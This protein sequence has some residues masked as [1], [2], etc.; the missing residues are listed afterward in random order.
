MINRVTSDPHFWHRRI[1]TFQNMNKYRH[2]LYETVEEMN[3]GIIDKF[4]EGVESETTTYVLG[5]V[6]LANGKAYADKLEGIL[7]A[8]LGDFVLVKGNHDNDTTAAV[9]KNF[10]FDTYD[11][12]EFDDYETKIC[13]SHFP[14]A[15]W[16]KS[17]YGSVM[18]HGHSHGTYRA[19]GGRILDVGWDVHG[20]VLG[21]HEAYKM[22]MKNEI[23]RANDHH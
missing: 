18:L 13:M 14:F 16:N 19:P 21:L 5:D 20:R 23:Y 9:F 11:Y 2:D 3:Q 22:A 1:L 17:H 4:N 12:I 10:G 15:V 6:C 7:D 8:L